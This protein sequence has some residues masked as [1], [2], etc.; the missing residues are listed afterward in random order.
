MSAP[1][2]SLLLLA[3]SA[4]LA[5]AWSPRMRNG[6][7]AAQA[8]AMLLGSNSAAVLARLGV[9]ASATAGPATLTFGYKDAQG[10]LHESAV[11]L[12]QDIAVFVDPTLEA[13]ANPE[14]PTVGKVHLGLDVTSVVRQLGSP[15]A[16]SAMDDAAVELRYPGERIVVAH[17]RVIAV[18]G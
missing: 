14:R 4:V 2:V 5:I 3:V 10:R 7:N 6:P 17:G 16:V 18:G 9:P 11:I 12:H 8:G 1:R 15:A 13:F